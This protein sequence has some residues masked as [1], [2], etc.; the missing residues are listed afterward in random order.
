VKVGQGAAGSGS[1]I[2]LRLEPNKAEVESPMKVVK[3]TPSFIQ[4]TVV[5][6]IDDVKIYGRRTNENRQTLNASHHE[7][8]RIEKIADWLHERGYAVKRERFLLD[9]KPYFSLEATWPGEGEG[10]Y[11]L[12]QNK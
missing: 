7:R 5:D 2:P 4:D 9:A 8:A 11:P 3:D 12:P 1:R 10:P 6:E